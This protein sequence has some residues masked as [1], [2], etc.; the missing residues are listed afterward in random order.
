MRSVVV[1]GIPR[2][3]PFRLQ[4]GARAFEAARRGM[5]SALDRPADEVVV[6]DAGV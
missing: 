2:V 6:V 1:H 5:T 4:D 3:G